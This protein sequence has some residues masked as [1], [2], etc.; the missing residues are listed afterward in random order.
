LNVKQL[1]PP[2]KFQLDRKGVV[3]RGSGKVDTDVHLRKDLVKTVDMV[4]VNSPS[5]KKYLAEIANQV[6]QMDDELNSQAS[7]DFKFKEMVSIGRPDRDSSLRIPLMRNLQTLRKYKMGTSPMQKAQIMRHSL[8]DP[9]DQTAEVKSMLEEMA[10]HARESVSPPTV[11]VKA[12]ATYDRESL[13]KTGND[14]PNANSNRTKIMTFDDDDLDI[15]LN[16]L[17]ERKTGDGVFSPKKKI[18]VRQGSPHKLHQY[19]TSSGS[20]KVE[21]LNTAPDAAVTGVGGE[22]VHPGIVDDSIVSSAVLETSPVSK[23]QTPMYSPATVR[24]PKYEDVP[25]FGNND[26]DVEKRLGAY[27]RHR[28]NAVA[29]AAALDEA[30][31]SELYSLTGDSYQEDRREAFFQSSILA[32]RSSQ[33]AAAAGGGESKPELRSVAEHSVASQQDSVSSAQT[34]PTV[35][36]TAVASSRRQIKPEEVLPANDRFHCSKCFKSAGLWC[37]TCAA[38]FC[39]ICWGQIPHHDLKHMTHK[40]PV[41]G[42]MISRGTRRRVRTTGSVERPGAGTVGAAGAGAGTSSGGGGLVSGPQDQHQEG[43]LAVETNRNSYSK[44][45]LFSTYPD[46]IVAVGETLS[47]EEKYKSTAAAMIPLPD[48]VVM[49]YEEY[50]EPPVEMDGTGHVS[51]VDADEPL[52]RPYT[53]PITTQR[54]LHELQMK[55]H[56]KKMSQKEQHYKMLQL[57]YP[58]LGMPSQMG[59]K[60]KFRYTNPFRG[61]MLGDSTHVEQMSHSKGE[62]VV[63]D[64]PKGAMYPG[65]RT[66]SK[67]R[68]ETP[69]SPHFSRLTVSGGGNNTDWKTA[70]FA[71]NDAPVVG[72]LSS[73]RNNT[74]SR[75]SP[76]RGSAKAAAAVATAAS[77]SQSM[78]GRGSA[79]ASKGDAGGRMGFSDSKSSSRGGGSASTPALFSSKG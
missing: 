53:A 59:V 26:P 69:S 36:S 60:T 78:R 52:L 31:A 14:S 9:L 76:S 43:Q 41:D 64:T 23:P 24:L 30:S 47:P 42:G 18:V 45:I 12:P 25:G 55:N 8:V 3:V 73:T 75:Q 71:S 34:L 68:R 21:H 39:G 32:D 65:I 5:R 13:N 57:R 7:Q 38:A 11:R 20:Q 51:A 79:A 16:P 1:V 44:S 2:S 56:F 48:R 22:N 72:A 58:N 70:L 77:S 33:L 49:K 6:P 66:V 50:P 40:G 62:V 63:R 74:G 28:E 37:Q 67:N 10:F 29:A 35:T 61:P 27:H 4:T 19:R 46:E 15:A 17:A 54:D